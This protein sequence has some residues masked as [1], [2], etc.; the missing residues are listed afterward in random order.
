MTRQIVSP[1]HGF[2]GVSGSA[3]PFYLNSDD[4]CEEK[5]GFT[6]EEP[7]QKSWVG[8]WDNVSS[9]DSTVEDEIVGSGLLTGIQ[10]A[11]AYSH[12]FLVPVFD[13]DLSR[14]LPLDP[15]VARLLPQQFCSENLIVP[16][17]DDGTTIDVAIVSPQGLM[18][19][20]EVLRISQRTMRAFFATK[21]VVAKA[22]EEIYKFQGT[23]ATGDAASP[24]D[25][26][27][28]TP[29]ASSESIDVEPSIGGTSGSDGRA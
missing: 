14:P 16:L 25:S 27:A 15:S 26:I 12:H 4:A 13:P 3:L 18:L 2:V 6:T 8:V 22:F 11:E 20:E 9:D 23:Q 29:V 5:V 1:P 7:S 17:A 24:T 21:E 28:F 19:R 10:L